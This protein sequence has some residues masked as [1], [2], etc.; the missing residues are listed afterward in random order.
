MLIP[1]SR[2]RLRAGARLSRQSPFG[3]INLMAKARCAKGDFYA[4]ANQREKRAAGFVSRRKHL[5]AEP[6][7]SP[8]KRPGSRVEIGSCQA[9]GLQ[10][11][12]LSPQFRKNQRAARLMIRPAP[13]DAAE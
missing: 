12:A 3:E 13:V 2:K 9:I 6:N 7:G 4:G 5:D 8:A 1:F 11:S 10:I